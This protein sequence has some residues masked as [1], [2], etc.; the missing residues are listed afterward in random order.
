MASKGKKVT[1][2]TEELGKLIDEIKAIDVQLAGLKGTAAEWNKKG[3]EAAR[4]TYVGTFI[5]DEDWQEADE[6]TDTPMLYPVMFPIFACTTVGE[7]IDTIRRH[8]EDAEQF[9]NELMVGWI[10][11]NRTDGDE[12]TA[13]KARREALVTDAESRRNIFVQLLGDQFDASEFEIPKAAKAS[14]GSGSSTPKKAGSMLFYRLVAGERVYQSRDQHSLSSMAYYYFKHEDKTGGT[15]G[16]LRAALASQ[17]GKV[18]ETVDWEGEVSLNGKVWTIGWHKVTDE[19]P[20]E[21]PTVNPEGYVPEAP[22]TDPAAIIAA[23]AVSHDKDN[24]E[25]KAD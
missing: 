18:D 19:T 10:K 23:M 3:T 1:L 13:L 24:E 11:A 20:A 9:G 5:P 25:V 15:V 2:S 14:G 21:G 7:Y 12:T 8:L 17:Y 6:A 22:S 4:A 16:E